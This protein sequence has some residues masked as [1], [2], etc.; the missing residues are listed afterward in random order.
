MYVYAAYGLWFQARFTVELLIFMLPLFLILIAPCLVRRIPFSYVLNHTYNTLIHFLFVALFD[1]VLYLGCYGSFWS[2]KVLFQLDLESTME[3]FCKVIHQIITPALL[4]AGM[5]KDMVE[6]SKLSRFVG[7]FVARVVIPV[8]A[9][10]TV[11]LCA[12]VIKIIYLME[13][14][15]GQVFIMV[16]VCGSVG[17]FSYFASFSYAKGNKY[18]EFF[19]NYFFLMFAP[20]LALMV[21]SLFLRIDQ[22]GITWPRYMGAMLCIGFTLLVLTS[23]VFW[24]RKEV[25]PAAALRYFFALFCITSV[26]PWN[27]RI[28]VSNNQVNRL[29]AIFIKNQLLSDGKIKVKKR[30]KVPYE[31]L[32]YISSVLERLTINKDIGLV[33]HW[34]PE[35]AIQ[36]LEE[37]KKRVQPYHQ[38]Y[39]AL[40]MKSVGLKPIPRYER[41][42]FKEATDK[43]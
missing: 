39:Y 32:C 30:N 33:M 16:G 14:P 43:K 23:F 41:H 18:L 36:Q 22:Y 7:F 28:F 25:L 19:Q 6:E 12:Y 35:K 21:Y 40:L 27:V 1:V 15:K 20:A 29:E 9:V 26:G 13:M 8:I 5:P 24:R 2:L 34:F 11:I 4:V 37:G 17:L 38:E 3:W 10:Y 42:Q 31:D